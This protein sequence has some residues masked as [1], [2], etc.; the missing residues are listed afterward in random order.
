[1]ALSLNGGPVILEPGKEHPAGF[2]SSGKIREALEQ[3]PGILASAKN[4][5]PPRN[6]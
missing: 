3:A 1:V 2:T 6:P 4:W 5:F